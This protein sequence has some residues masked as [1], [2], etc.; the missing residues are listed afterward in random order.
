MRKCIEQLVNANNDKKVSNH[1]LEITSEGRNYFLYW[2]CICK[3]RGTEFI[4]DNT[5]GT[6]TTTCTTNSYRNYFTSIGY[7]EVEC[8]SGDF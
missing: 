7:K 5:Y 8:F 1:R 4:I 3:T 6:R 2:T